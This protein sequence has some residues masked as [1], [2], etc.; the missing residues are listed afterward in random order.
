MIKVTD[1]VII[2]SGIEPRSRALPAVQ[3]LSNGDLI[4]AY[5]DA[6]THPFG[7]ETIIDD[8]VVA[9][10]R[11]IDHGRNWNE[12]RTICALPGWDC[13]GGRSMV[14]TPDDSLLMFLMKARRSV[15]DKKVSAV[16]PVRSYDYGQT[17]TDF[18]PEL[19]LYPGGWTEPN[20]TGYMSVL[21]DGRWMMPAYGSDSLMGQTFPC[22]AFSSDEGE[23]WTGRSAIAKRRVG[24]TFYE[25]SIIRL[26][27]GRYLAIVRT[28]D[29][30]YTSYQ[31]YSVDE[32]ETW[33]VAMPVSFR[34]QT[35]FL[36]ELQSDVI[37]CAYRDMTPDRFG[38]AASVT[39]D[40]GVTWNYVGHIYE[41]KDWNCGYPSLIR[42]QDMQL[43][44]VYYTCYEDGN[45]EVHGAFVEHA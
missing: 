5:R 1:R 26:R 32:G 33:S 37:M 25:P 30:P 39:Y 2:A 3:L 19:A 44:C 34:G 8:G 16:Y 31:T 20:T 4:V 29:P 36:F 6:S 12:P 38:V 43:F 22:V 41:G 9:I 24:I 40:D 11:S 13:A 28:M 7:V 35:P 15:P 17:W 42:L 21:S 18:G 10:V 14:Q 23:T 45:S 27:D